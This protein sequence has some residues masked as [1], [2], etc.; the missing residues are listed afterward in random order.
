M[1]DNVDVKVTQG[2]PNTEYTS[3]IFIFQGGRK[4]YD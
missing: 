4:F 3:P 1:S 2:G